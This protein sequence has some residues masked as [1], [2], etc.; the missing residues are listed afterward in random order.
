LLQRA[1]EMLR[2]PQTRVLD[3]AVGLQLQNA[4]ALCASVPTCVLSQPYPISI[5]GSALKASAIRSPLIGTDEM[6]IYRFLPAA[7]CVVFW[8]RSELTFLLLRRRVD[9]D[10]KRGQLAQVASI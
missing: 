9:E 8:E 1:K 5:R 2:T 3:V 10:V 7:Q 6:R 4:A